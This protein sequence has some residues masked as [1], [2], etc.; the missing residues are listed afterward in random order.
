MATLLI[1]NVSFAN[2]ILSTFSSQ[3]SEIGSFGEPDSGSTPTFG[4]VFVVP[5]SPW[6]QSVTFSIVNPNTTAIPF[7]MYVYSWDGN[8]ISGS[9]LYVSPVQALEPANLYQYVSVQNVD[10]RLN[11]GDTAIA[12]FSTLGFSGEAGDAWFQTAPDSA[13]SDGT[14]AFNNGTSLGDLSTN[15]GSNAFGNLAFEMDF[16]DASAT[17][18]PASLGLAGCA[19]IVIAFARRKTA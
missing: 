5:N 4:Q 19:C 2:T 13:Y 8:E 18:E 10:L 14:F 3:D 6:L 9:S 7:Q 16:T 15:W 1:P 11:P 12:F 17:P